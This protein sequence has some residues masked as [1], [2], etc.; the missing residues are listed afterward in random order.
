MIQPEIE[1][2]A[3]LLDILTV[4]KLHFSCEL[5]LRTLAVLY[6]VSRAYKSLF[7]FCQINE[8][9][10]LTLLVAGGLNLI[11]GIRISSAL[12]SNENSITN[13]PQLF[14][15]YSKISQIMSTRKYWISGATQQPFQCPA[16]ITLLLNGESMFGESMFRYYQYLEQLNSCIHRNNNV[17]DQLANRLGALKR[18]GEL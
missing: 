3:S 13:G 16:N 1:I 14:E 4:L 6:G 18:S 8:I 12:C 17:D 15:N 10:K 2:P 5:E 9:N 7:E 11:E